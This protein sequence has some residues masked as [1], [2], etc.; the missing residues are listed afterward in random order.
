MNV[1]STLKTI[2]AILSVLML[3]LEILFMVMV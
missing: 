1:D 3:V 2:G